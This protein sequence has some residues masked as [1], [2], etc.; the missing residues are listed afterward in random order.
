MLSVTLSGNLGKDAELRHT[1]GDDVLG[2][3]VAV[4]NG[5]KRDAETEW[6]RCNLWGKRASSLQQYLTKGTKVVVIG[7]LTIGEYQ[8]NV[9]F[10]V[11][12]REVEIMS[13]ADGGQQRREPDGSRGHTGQTA[14]SS[15]DYNPLDD[16]VPFMTRDGV[17]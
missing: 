14:D 4:K 9:Q 16:D 11:N 7:D 3:S 17:F 1:S 15:S 2:F 5:Y 8:G 13:R 6:F 10:D 12:V